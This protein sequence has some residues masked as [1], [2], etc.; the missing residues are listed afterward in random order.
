MSDTP[1][2][3]DLKFL[4]DW[5]KESE[6]ASNRYA[7]YEGEPERRGRSDRGPR[8]NRGPRPGGPGGNRDFRGPRPGGPGGPGGNRGPRPSGPGGPRQDR[9]PRPGGPGG[10]GGNR[11][12][13]P[14]GDRG[15]RPGG[16]RPPFGG[17][18][19][20]RRDDRRDD[21]GPRDDRRGFRHDGPPVEP[22]AVRVEFLPEPAAVHAIAKQIRS[23]HR[24]FPLFGTGRL[25]LERPE[26]HR[27]RITSLKEDAPLFQVGDGPISFDRGTVE[28]DAFRQ[29]KN[30]YYT[31]TVE[32]GEAPKGTFTKVARLRHGGLILGPTN[33]HSY[34]PTLRRIYEERFSRRM[35]FADF[36]QYEIEV[37]SD[38]QT[39]NEWKEQARSVTTWTTTQ[40]AEP[41]VF[42]TAAEVEAHFR[43]QYMPQ[44]LR[45]GLT[46]EANGAAARA[47]GDRSLNASI[48]LA[49]ERE[50]GFPV[51]IVNAMR[52]ALN[53]AAL[54]F[55][56]HRKRVVYVSTIRPLHHPVGQ[57]AKQ[58][59]LA[60]LNAIEAMPRCSRHDLAIK[61]LGEHP[62]APEKE[63]DK[64]ALASDLHYLL[65]AGHVV[66]FADGTLD[67]PLAPK[68]AAAEAASAGPEAAAHDE[69]S[70]VGATETAEPATPTPAV[71]SIASTAAP[72]L[73]SSAVVPTAAPEIPEAP[74]PV[75]EPDPSI[76]EAIS[77]EPATVAANESLTDPIEDEQAL[78]E[79]QPEVSPSP[80][81]T[82]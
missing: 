36:Q 27:L 17:G 19:G 81:H 22:A 74:A 38:E 47:S 20:P 79:T 54:H 11:G 33:Y 24:A 31:E 28:R 67:L 4:P 8:D 61:L 73:E 6:P 55:F 69:M 45:T 25:F 63:A 1:E 48:R 13:R 75:A 68:A 9:G 42:K 35:S 70:A 71:E 40:E 64:Q 37:V 41:I 58:N 51:G 16:N 78:I 7:D 82:A 76:P 44:E 39:V 5:L 21:R 12:P 56:K 18:G 10:P 3:P 26:R 57:P 23:S 62:E 65:L 32:Q 29:L 50:R 52:P 49:T 34:Q 77:E 14:E 2:F 15:P 53:E 30:R 46:L 66:E 72:N 80:T 60:I 43:R 59:I